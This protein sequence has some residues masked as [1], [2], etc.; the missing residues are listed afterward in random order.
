MMQE[1]PAVHMTI[2]I[3]LLTSALLCPLRHVGT[4]VRSMTDKDQCLVMLDVSIGYVEKCS[5]SVSDFLES[6]SI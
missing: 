6:V 4:V 2:I 5:K 1:D 3:V